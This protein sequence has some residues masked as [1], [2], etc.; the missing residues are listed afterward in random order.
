[1]HLI[2]L[3]CVPLIA[4]DKRIATEV[5]RV[6][7][8]IAAKNPAPC[9]R[10][11]SPTAFGPGA[12]SA[13]GGEKERLGK[14]LK[15]KPS[16]PLRARERSLLFARQFHSHIWAWS[17]SLTVVS[18]YSAPSRYNMPRLIIT[19]RAAVQSAMRR[20]LVRK[21][22]CCL[23]LMRERWRKMRNCQLSCCNQVSR[24]K[25]G[26]FCARARN[27][28]IAFPSLSLYSGGVV[29]ARTAC[30]SVFQPSLL[31]A[32]QGKAAPREAVIGN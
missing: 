24:S 28:P 31:L 21:C 12:L 32:R 27:S 10:P 15:K 13:A 4:A 11:L 5:A 26:A 18:G 30:C 6:K 16:R 1:M 2:Y 8:Y 17:T 20:A 29:G 14:K 25:S 3:S 23:L 9:T 22:C 7:Q 19:A